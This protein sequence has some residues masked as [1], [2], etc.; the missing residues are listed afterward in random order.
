MPLVDDYLR[1]NQ[2]I[3]LAVGGLEVVYEDGASDPIKVM[4]VVDEIQSAPTMQSG[5]EVKR[6]KREL[7]RMVHMPR[8]TSA[9]G[10]GLDAPKIN[11]EVTNEG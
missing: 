1:M 4:C 9:P 2:D 6:N 5:L 11:A 7:T 10:G 3:E 8:D